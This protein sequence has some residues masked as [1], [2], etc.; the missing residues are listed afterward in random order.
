M[1]AAPDHALRN[2]FDLEL[3]A[4]ATF[5]CGPELADRIDCLR[6]QEE[7]YSTA[8]SIP[9]PFQ[10]RFL[11]GDLLVLSINVFREEIELLLQPYTAG[12]IAYQESGMRSTVSEID[13]NF[14]DKAGRLTLLH[15]LVLVMLF[16]EGHVVRACSLMLGT[17]DA[18]IEVVRDEGLA[19]LS[20]SS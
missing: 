12:A 11:R 1:E 5:I 10:A 13:R 16:R 3:G 9:V 2:R 15:R 17:R 14:E 18:V 20:D 4:L 6:L 19:R 7:A 8:K